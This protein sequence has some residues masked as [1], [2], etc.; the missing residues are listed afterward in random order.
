MATDA[1]VF[2]V[3]SSENRFREWTTK[4]FPANLNDFKFDERHFHDCWDAAVKAVLN[5]IRHSVANH[6]RKVFENTIG[7]EGH[8]I[9]QWAAAMVYA[10][11]EMWMRGEIP[12][13]GRIE[14]PYLPSGPLG[15]AAHAILA[16]MGY[17]GECSILDKQ[18]MIAVLHEGLRAVCKTYESVTE[19]G[20]HAL[21]INENCQ[22]LAKY[23]QEIESLLS[24]A[25]VPHHFEDG[26]PVGPCGRVQLLIKQR[27]NSTNM[28]RDV[29][30]L[31][32]EAD[33]ATCVDGKPV[34]FVDRVRI[35]VE[36]RDEARDVGT[37]DS[38]TYL[39][40]IDKLLTDL[41]VEFPSH[42]GGLFSLVCNK[43]NR[44]AE[45]RDEAKA[46]W[47]EDAVNGLYNQ[48]RLCHQLL[49]EYGIAKDNDSQ[50]LPLQN[51]I[52]LLQ[53]E[54]DDAHRALEDIKSFLVDLGIEA[55]RCERGLPDEIKDQ[56]YRLSQK[57]DRAN[58]ALGRVALA[59]SHGPFGDKERVELLGEVLEIPNL[60]TVIRCSDEDEPKINPLA[61]S[62]VTVGVEHYGV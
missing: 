25:K 31:L 21:T 38:M 62:V 24:G 18:G 8:E 10:D 47:N 33:I 20:E 46:K 32:S 12:A 45:Q 36:Q 44:L 3:E 29:H 26:S 51:R 13:G 17:L 28:I 14:K 52:Q 40:D 55:R 50:G 2:P 23:V 42:G 35:A 39:R 57:H 59:L 60:S 53:R 49:D 5:V 61:S 9:G 54:R 11:V 22:R 43:I 6:P 41:K 48:R 16:A 15:E 1:E 27:D 19:A 56:V 37:R 34:G 58:G 7:K 30:A 4:P